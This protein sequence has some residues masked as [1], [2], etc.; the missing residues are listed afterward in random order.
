[1]KASRDETDDARR[2]G[3]HVVL[4]GVIGVNVM[5]V[6]RDSALEDR[7]LAKAREWDDFKDDNPFGHGNSK[8]RPCS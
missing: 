7:E 8:L 1:M 6:V 5:R 2:C 3:L 4:L